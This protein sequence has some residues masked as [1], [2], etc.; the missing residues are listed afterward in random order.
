MERTADPLLDGP[1]P[2]PPGAWA[3]TPDQISAAEPPP[4]GVR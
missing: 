2:L 1:V 4:V 3:N